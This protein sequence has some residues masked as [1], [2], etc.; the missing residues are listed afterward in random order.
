[1]R[2]SFSKSKSFAISV[3]W[4][5]TM[6]R[7]TSASW[8][9][10]S[11]YLLIE[12]KGAPAGYVILRGIASVNGSVELK[13]I[14]IADPGRGVGRQALAAVI[15][16]VFREFRAHRLWLDVFED[17]SRARHVYCALGFAEEGVL[18]ECIKRG[19]TYRSLV[20]MS[21]LATEFESR[22]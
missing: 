17:N 4:V 21:M 16:K 13:R 14:V 1:L 12:T 15:D 7:R 10:P 3:L 5:A 8:P 6:R 19:E 22:Q 2:S 9:I 11:L 20:V 18:R